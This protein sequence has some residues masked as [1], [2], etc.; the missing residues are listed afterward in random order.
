MKR[1]LLLVSV[2]AILFSL[3][4]PSVFAGEKE[5]IVKAVNEAVAILEQEGEAGLEKVGAMRLAG[6]NYLFVNS[7][8]GTTL[9]HIKKHLIGKNMVAMGLKDDKGKNF[10]MEFTKVAKS[11]EGEGWVD[12]RWT[13]PDDPKTFYDKTTFIK[14]AKMGDKEVYVGAGMYL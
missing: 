10:F 13:K 12:Y 1:L 4:P 7:L 8:D 5:E 6:D 2:V 14:K 9:M 11:P 3:T